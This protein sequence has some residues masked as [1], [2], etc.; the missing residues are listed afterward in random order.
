MFDKRVP[1]HDAAKTNMCHKD[2]DKTMLQTYKKSALR[3]SSIDGNNDVDNVVE[4]VTNIVEDV[5]EDIAKD[6]VKD[7]TNTPEDDTTPAPPPPPIKAIKRNTTSYGP[8]YIAFFLIAMGIVWWMSCGDGTESKKR[9][10]LTH[11]RTYTRALAQKS[12]SVAPI[13]NS[14]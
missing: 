3:F 11:D 5:A 14:K 4:Q 7:D 8:Y 6:A 13:T 12:P 9:I 2:K 10:K 1:I